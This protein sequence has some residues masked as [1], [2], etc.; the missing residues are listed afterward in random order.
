MEMEK[1][2]SQ[3]IKFS[4][5]NDK[6]LQFSFRL[7][8]NGYPSNNNNGYPNNNSGRPNNNNG[9]P[10]NNNNGY[11]SNNNGY[12]SNNGNSWTLQSQIP[13]LGSPRIDKDKETSITFGEK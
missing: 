8:N 2:D 12:P 6:L 3:T 13:G 7:N 4:S 5:L 11:P 9:Y 1:Q 10:S